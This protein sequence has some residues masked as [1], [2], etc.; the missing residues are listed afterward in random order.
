M[1]FAEE[2]AT[3]FEDLEGEKKSKFEEEGQGVGEESIL[4]EEDKPFKWLCN[5]QAIDIVGTGHWQHI[6]RS[7][8]L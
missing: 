3:E 2:E 8:L 1:T 4:V 6:Q 7:D 5:T